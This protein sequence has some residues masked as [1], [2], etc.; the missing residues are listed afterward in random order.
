LRRNFH[1]SR[2]DDYQPDSSSGPKTNR[3]PRPRIGSYAFFVDPSLSAL[4][5]PVA[6]VT[7]TGIATLSAI[8]TRA[9]VAS[10]ADLNLSTLTCIRHI[11]FERGDVERLLIHTTDAAIAVI[12][13]GD[14]IIKTPVDVVFHIDG[15]AR[16]HSAGA[17]LMALPR[18]LT[19]PPRQAVKS[20]R[21]N[22]LRNAL[23]A[24]DGRRAGASYR[25]MAAVAFGRTKTAVAWTS[26][27]RAMKD[28]MF[29]A[30][31]RGIELAGG[32]HIRLL[33]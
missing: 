3:R 9:A 18:V 11:V 29:R 22:L 31:D 5:A 30:H 33:G 12:L 24:L 2:S 19:G 25:E 15:L 20:V 4:D 26:P 14:R 23:I 7:D 28:Q 10:S 13:R 21:R 8:A 17:V 1:Q 27:S 32:G 16:A 6:W